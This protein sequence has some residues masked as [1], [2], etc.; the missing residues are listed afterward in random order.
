MSA[1]V[2]VRLAQGRRQARGLPEVHQQE[3][4][5]RIGADFPLS[6]R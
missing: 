6:G 5:L 2:I 4:A 3:F 1:G